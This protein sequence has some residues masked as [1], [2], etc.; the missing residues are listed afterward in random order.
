ML[1]SVLPRSLG[2]V[3]V[4][5]AAWPQ[6][7][8]N[9]GRT[10]PPPC[11]GSPLWAGM[12][13][14]MGCSPESG[15]QTDKILTLGLI[16]KKMH[17][18]TVVNLITISAWHPDSLSC[19]R[20]KLLSRS[21]LSRDH[22]D[23]QTWP[24]PV[25]FWIWRWSALLVYASVPRIWEVQAEDE[26]SSAPALHLGSSTA[27][28]CWD[29]SCSDSEENRKALKTMANLSGQ[30]KGQRAPDLLLGSQTTSSIA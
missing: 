8:G 22:M 1:S 7:C 4:K 25:L 27:W 12:A 17:Y 15:L 30:L 18:V 26:L 5:W 19:F 10:Q 16:E 13:G 6:A 28:A 3:E 23:T 11:H 14:L 20:A 21:S 29:G 24:R 2:A 9:W